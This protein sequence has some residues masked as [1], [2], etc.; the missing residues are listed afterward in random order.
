MS[1][2]RELITQF[3]HKIHFLATVLVSVHHIETTISGDKMSKFL[4]VAFAGV[5]GAA[6]V[7]V[8]YSQ[9]S[10]VAG[11]QLGQ[12]GIADYIATYEARLKAPKPDSAS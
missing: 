2:S 11:V 1:G 5:L 8:D 12:F 7:G 10:A 9:Q 4:G 6:F 3:S